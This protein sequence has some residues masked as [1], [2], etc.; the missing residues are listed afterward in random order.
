M[1]LKSISRSDILLA[2]I[3]AG[4]KRG[5]TRVFIQKIV[6]LVSEEYKGSLSADFYEFDKFHYGP[7]S[8]E[9]Y[10]DA[11]MLNDSGCIRI[12]YGA[13]RRDDTYSIDENC[14]LDDIHLP[15]DLKET[16]AE[17]VAWV[18]DMSFDELVRAIYLLHPEYRENSRF[19][20]NE[21]QALAESF[22]RGLKQFREGKSYSS[23]EGLA[24]LRKV[25]ANH[26]TKD[27][28]GS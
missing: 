9:V 3:A 11:E 5:L 2:I 17:T 8:R 12:R 23:A 6:F 1:D 14:C 22:V 25:M 4:G 7:F 24:R 13:D 19:P 20:Y 18:E 16:I 28:M 10:L 21:G 15:T 27:P 26:G